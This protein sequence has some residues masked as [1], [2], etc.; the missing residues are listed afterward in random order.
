VLNTLAMMILS[1]V[2]A[3]G[4]VPAEAQ[5]AAQSPSAAP[6]TQP[7]DSS[8]MRVYDLRD[9]HNY[10]AGFAGLVASMGE[11][12][13]VQHIRP[14]VDGVWAVWGDQPA[15]DAFST[16]LDQTRSLYGPGYRVSV[17]WI[18]IG[19]ETPAAGDPYRAGGGTDRIEAGIDRIVR[20]RSMTSFSSTRA[21]QHVTDWQPIVGDGAVGYDPDIQTTRS[22]LDLS[23]FVAQA[24]KSG[25][26]VEVVTRGAWIT[27]EIR[28]VETDQSGM[29]LPLELAETETMPLDGAVRATLGTPT[30]VAVVA[31]EEQGENLALVIEVNKA[32]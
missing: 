22:G 28:R 20:A 16:L 2:L 9:L 7:E 29:V 14:M 27:S 30:V 12:A 32:R 26:G 31:G 24:D 4:G 21:E 5:P 17:R 13:R 1:G 11:F 15:H 10:D 8:I 18:A 23:V 19:D 3:S 25:Q 6:S